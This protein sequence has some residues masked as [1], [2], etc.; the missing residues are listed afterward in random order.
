MSPPARLV[1]VFVTFLVAS[2]IAQP[3][4]GQDAQQDN[5]TLPVMY[6]A[7]VV[8]EGDATCPSSEEHVILAEIGQEVRTLIQEA[9]LP[10]IQCPGIHSQKPAMSCL[11]IAECDPDIQ[12]SSPMTHPQT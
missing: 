5:V 8:P 4:A 2:Y 9:V 7:K 3:A 6:S 11:Q 10:T 12:P 1:H